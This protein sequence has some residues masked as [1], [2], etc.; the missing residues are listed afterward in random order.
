[1]LALKRVVFLAL[2]FVFGLVFFGALGVAAGFGSC[3]FGFFFCGDLSHLLRLRRRFLCLSSA[4]LQTAAFTADL[5][6]FTALCFFTYDSDAARPRAGAVGAAAFPFF[7]AAN[8]NDPG[9]PLPLVWTTKPE[10]TAFFKYVLMK[11]EIFSES[12]RNL[13]Q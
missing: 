12:I 9:A 1:M 8:L 13:R 7:A 4:L 11:G 2:Y 5:V 3:A 6:P 10:A